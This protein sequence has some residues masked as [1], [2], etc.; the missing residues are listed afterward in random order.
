GAPGWL[1]WLS[2]R[3]RLRSD[4]TLSCQPSEFRTPNC[5]QNKLPGC[6]RDF[7]PVCGSNMPTHPK[8]CSLCMKIREDGHDNEIIQSGPC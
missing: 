8:E 3:L 1:S 7:S 2:L 6:P 4:L 5:N